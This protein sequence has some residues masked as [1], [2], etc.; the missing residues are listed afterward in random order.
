MTSFCNT[1]ASSENV[2]AISLTIAAADAAFVVVV[3]HKMSSIT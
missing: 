2:E 1:L 3:L